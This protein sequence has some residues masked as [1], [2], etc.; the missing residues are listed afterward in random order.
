LA[1][2]ALEEEPRQLTSWKKVNSSPFSTTENHIGRRKYAQ[3]T[4]A[5]TSN[6]KMSAHVQMF[7]HGNQIINNLKFSIKL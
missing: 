4:K 7:T 3:I 1:G 6:K 5:I 2:T